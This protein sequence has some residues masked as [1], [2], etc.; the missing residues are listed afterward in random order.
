MFSNCSSNEVN[1][2]PQNVKY[3]WHLVN[4]TGGVAGVDKTFN[5]NTVVWAFNDET[6][7]L[8]VENNN[9]DQAAEDG[10]D[11][12]TYDFD[13]I[14]IDGKTYLSIND[15]E[16][17]NFLVSGNLLTINQNIM[18]SGT[19]ADGFVYTFQRTIELVN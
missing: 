3:L 14:E 5:L 15:N 8:V 7:K 10:L 6:K 4:V 2:D 1:V 12:G 11:S 17:G 13:V 18:S 19:G 16:F 9:D